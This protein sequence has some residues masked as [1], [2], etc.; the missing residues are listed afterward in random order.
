MIGAALAKHG[1]GDMARV[2]AG[3]GVAREG[4]ADEGGVGGKPD[5]RPRKHITRNVGRR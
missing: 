4:N 3:P 2:F 5:L 1:G